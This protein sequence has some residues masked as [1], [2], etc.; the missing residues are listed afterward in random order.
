MNDGWLVTNPRMDIKEERRKNMCLEEC[1][2]PCFQ[3]LLIILGSIVKTIGG[4]GV[5][6]MW[7]TYDSMLNITI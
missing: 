2:K 1:I 3:K 6:S 7:L 4:G 5:R